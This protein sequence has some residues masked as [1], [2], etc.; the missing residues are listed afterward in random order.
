MFLLVRD[1]FPLNLDVNIF[2]PK[3]TSKIQTSNDKGE[4]N[5]TLINNKF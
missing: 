4:T 1:I 3:T 2:L 5:H